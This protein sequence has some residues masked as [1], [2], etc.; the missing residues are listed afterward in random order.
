MKV[1][2][3][4]DE[5]IILNHT[6]SML[7][8]LDEFDQVIGFNWVDDALAYINE[9]RDINLAF[10]DIEMPGTN[11]IELARK[12]RELAPEIMI[13]Y[14]TGFSNY[15]LDAFDIGAIGYLLKPIK[16]EKVKECLSRIKQLQGVK[17]SSDV[18][19]IKT[20]GNF[21]VYYKGSPVN[22]AYSRTKEMLAYL[23]DRKGADC[24]LNE[25][26]AALFEE[27][28]HSSYIRTLKK[29]LLDTL[30]KI[31]QKDIIRSNRGRIGLEKDKVKCD[32]YDYLNG[33]ITEVPNEY[34]SQ[35]SFGEVTLASLQNKR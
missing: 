15:A 13:I 4:D 7:E 23:V 14:V 33:D 2:C 32:Y 12:I 6:V 20:F 8:K 27:D 25:I 29:N 9:N 16:V 19:S 21:E 18:I 26:Q 17:V 24:T 1:I 28:V 30:E 35:Y 34:M 22:F 3:I 10:L 11:G 5:K 31:G